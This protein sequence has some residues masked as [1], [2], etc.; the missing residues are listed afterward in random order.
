MSTYI[1]SRNPHLN[2]DYDDC[3]QY[4]KNYLRDMEIIKGLS[5]RTVNGYYIDLRLFFKFIKNYK[6][7]S[8][9]DDFSSIVIK[10]IDLQFIEQISTN[11]VYEFLYYV[12][13][14]SKN[15]PSTRA[16]KLSSI[17]GFF[18]YLCN[19]KKLLKNNPADDIDSPIIKK[20]LPKYLTLSDSFALLENINSDFYERDYCII[21]LFLNCG[22]RLSELI[23]INLLDIRNDEQTMRIVG[24]GNKERIVYLNDA[25]ISTIDALIKQRAKMENLKDEKAL[26]VSKKTGKR[27]SARRVQQIVGNCLSAA[28]LSGQGYSPHKLRHT[29]A[30]LMY[31]E[32]NVDMLAL[33]EILGHEHVSTTEIYTHLNNEN[34]KKAAHASPFANVKSKPSK[35]KNNT[36]INKKQNNDN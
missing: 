3:P 25:C 16:R 18:K 13:R 10:D 1:D 7:I 5:T 20:S 14:Q 30:T 9:V 23:N 21:T 17:K 15:N 19:K 11:D 6:E 29:A 12:T 22:M 24:K 33:K 34:L 28:G 4:L 32:G 26:F 36:E 35:S 8:P 31:Q 27:L 2:T